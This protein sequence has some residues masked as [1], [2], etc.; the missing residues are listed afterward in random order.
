MDPVT[1]KDI[2]RELQAI[3]TVDPSSDFV[4]RIRTAIAHEPATRSIFPG[5]LF[6]GAAAGLV[7]ALV[8]VAWVDYR[9]PEVPPVVNPPPPQSVRS[10][11]PL[12]PDFTP[13][14]VPA[15]RAVPA[16]RRR[17]VPASGDPSPEVII[18]TADVNAYRRLL[19]SMNEQPLAL[20]FEETNLERA[21]N[22]LAISP[23]AIKALDPFSE[24]PG[25]LQ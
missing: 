10:N 2:D 18:S 16:A 17:V 24:Q 21:S 1:D 5:L 25:V 13:A 19:R 14:P 12:S 22:E 3:L 20:S 8:L 9:G 23:I 11:T 4:A 15:A 7:L 6:R